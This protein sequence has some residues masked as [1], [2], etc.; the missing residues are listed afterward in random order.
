MGVLRPAQRTDLAWLWAA[1]RNAQLF[2]DIHAFETW[3]ADAPWR[4]QVDSRGEAAVVCRWREHLDIMAIRALWCSERRVPTLLEQLSV[5]ARDQ[6]LAR[7][8]SPL[9]PMDAMRPYEEFGMRPVDDIVVLRIDP[10][11]RKVPAGVAEGV[12][13]RVASAEDLDAVLA[14]DTSAFKDFWRYDAGLLAR[15]AKVERL[16]VAEIGGAM[17]GY[18]LCTLRRGD[19]SIGRLAVRPEAQGRGVGSSLLDDAL[20][21]LARMDARK[22]TLCTQ[23][24]NMRSRGLYTRTGF[25]TV[26][27]TL[28]GLLSGPL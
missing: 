19:G 28:V 8:L 26:P 16:A 6:G 9:V 21:H 14:V 4:V 25:E 7:L 5:I 13:I 22:V 2:D 1:A 20:G 11:G 24:D 15:Y 27:G 23:S 18:T 10:R 12:R 3:W 17:V